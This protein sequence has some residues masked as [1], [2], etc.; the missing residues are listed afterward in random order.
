MQGFEWVVDCMWKRVFCNNKY[1]K[2]A[3][4]SQK[5]DIIITGLKKWNVNYFTEA[6]DNLLAGE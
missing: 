1:D 2:W 4:V 5:F 3:E 6:G